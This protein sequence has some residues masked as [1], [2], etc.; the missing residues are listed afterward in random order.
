AGFTGSADAAVRTLLASPDG[1]SLAVGG[2]FT[3]LSGQSRGFVGAIDL[4][5]AATAWHP[6]IP[7][8]DVVLPCYLYDL[9]QDQGTIYAGVGGPGG[10]VTAYDRVTGAI[11]WVA[12][13]DGDVQG[14][15]VYGG[16]VYAGGHFDLSFAGQSRAGMVALRASSGAVLPDFAPQV[17]N[18][19]G[20]FDILPGPD[21]LRIGGG[22]EIV[23]ATGEQR[24]TE[25]PLLPDT[26]PPTAPANL[27]ATAVADTSAT[28]AWNASTDNDLVAGY[29]VLRDGLALATVP[30]TTW[31]DP[32]PAPGTTY[33][34][35]VQSLDPAGN[36]S[37]PSAPLVLTTRPESQTLIGAGSGW[38]YL[39]NGSNQGTAWQA[40]AFADSGWPV[41]SAQLGYGDGDEATVISAT[42]LTHYFR[43]SFTAAG[44]GAFSALTAR[45]LRDD[46][47]IVYL[48]GT[49]VWR[50]NMPAGTVGSTTPAASAVSGTAEGQYLTQAVPVA[51]LVAG[52][53]VVAV[54][55]HNTS[56]SS[57]VSFD[58][59]LVGAK[60]IAPDLT[61]PSTPGTLRAETVTATGAGL[62]WDAS[63]DDRAVTG[64]RVARDG[65][66]VAT[67]STTSWTDSGRTPGATSAYTVQALD[68]AGNASPAAGPL[69]VTLPLPLG[70]LVARGATWRY[71][72][73]DPGSGWARTGFDDTAWGSGRAELGF[74]DGGEATVLTGGSLAYYFR[75]TF[76]VT[77]PS[78][79]TSLSL[80]LVRDDGAAVYVNGT[81][82]ARSNLPAGAL[83]PTTRASANVSGTAES[84]P[85]SFSVP[86]GVLV[87]GD[88]VIAV[89]VHQDVVTSSDVSFDLGLTAG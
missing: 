8:T 45:L 19:L 26:Q 32:T 52:T 29:R 71:R 60:A 64:Y 33:T 83:T 30:S 14:I 80:S 53:N 66:V 88:N 39:S 89:E 68:A 41:G 63:T 65:V 73:G 74:G 22:F 46:G 70:T 61:P 58:L 16:V 12:T 84:A 55:V 72:A 44:P 69:T 43:Q 27:R 28:L 11:R 79:V 13:G 3:T 77:D 38:R 51:A 31:T 25:F 4:N 81:E 18:G 1:T 24:Y 76:S 48:N 50:S 23:D 85:V 75:T 82:V 7:C 56:G 67:V 35:T 17:L 34:Y 62:A 9:A 6:P 5:G 37:A 54:E 78:A 49:E 86:P 2:E 21:Q 59:E 40:P 10:R 57:D 47:A 36:V 42:G 87:A 20:V 15:A